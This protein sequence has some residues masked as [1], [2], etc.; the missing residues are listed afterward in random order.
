MIGS[1]IKGRSFPDAHISR[2]ER[3]FV[4]FLFEQQRANKVHE[5]NDAT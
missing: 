3:P 2:A 5:S 4:I 1:S